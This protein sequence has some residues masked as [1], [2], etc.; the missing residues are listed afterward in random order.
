MKTT[1]EVIEAIRKDREQEGMTLY[2]LVTKHGLS[3]STI[4]N[5]IKGMD[6]SLVKRASPS[7][8]VVQTVDHEVRPDLSKTDLGEASRQMIC[9][10]LMLAGVKVFRPMTED[11]PTDLLVLKSDGKVLQCQCKYIWPTRRGCHMMNLYAV[12]KNGP[13]SKAVLHPYTAQEVDVFL[14]Y[15][16]DNDSVYII[17]HAACGGRK[18]LTLWINRPS[19]GS[20]GTDGLDCSVFAKAYDQLR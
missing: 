11:T 14:G 7:R 16:L 2:Q 8:R 10:R 15:C 18:M 17:P 20:C 5:I 1:P 4:H 13:N 9:A 3:K 19:A 12:R 6:A